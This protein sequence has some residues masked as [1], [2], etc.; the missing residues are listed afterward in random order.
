MGSGDASCTEDQNPSCSG[1]AKAGECDRNPAFMKTSCCMSCGLGTTTPPPTP[2]PTPAP[3]MAAASDCKDENPSC[4]PWSTAGECERNPTWM[5]ANCKM[6]CKACEAVPAAGANPAMSATP[7]VPGTPGAAAAVPTTQVAT[8]TP[9][10]ATSDCQTATP[11]NPALKACYDAVTWVFTNGLTSNPD[12]FPGLTFSSPFESVQYKMHSDGR[13]PMPCA[14]TNDGCKSAMSDM[15]SEC[16]KAVIF[17][18]N[19]GIYGHPEWFPELKASSPIDDF[20]MH[21]HNQNATL[22]PKPCKQ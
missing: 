4:V 8:T 5:K 19:D 17:A 16:Y 22:C 15:N 14:P 7:G 13:C 20:Q 1:W 10:W 11:D 3:M 18:K 9:V 6:S 12:W 21:L 2:P